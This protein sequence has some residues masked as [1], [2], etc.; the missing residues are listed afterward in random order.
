MEKPFWFAVVVVAIVFFV[1]PAVYQEYAMG[2][3]QSGTTTVCAGLPPAPADVT[4]GRHSDGSRWSWA[5]VGYSNDCS[6]VVASFASG[7]H[8][9]P[10]KRVQGKDWT[11]L[12]PG[13]PAY[14]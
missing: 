10:V 11:P 5:V 6:I 13:G 8:Y 1:A 7:N 2:L 3:V 14:W 4:L 9:Y 12:P